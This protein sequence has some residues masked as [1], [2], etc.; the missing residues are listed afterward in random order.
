[1][2][3]YFLPVFVIYL[4]RYVF[5]SLSLPLWFIDFV[6]ISLF[7]SFIHSSISALFIYLFIYCVLSV[8][9]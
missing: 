8:C 4:F 1:V 9:I 2:N 6:I 3:E 5:M 7:L